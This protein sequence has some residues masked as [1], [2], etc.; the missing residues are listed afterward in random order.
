MEQRAETL[1]YGSEVVVH[2]LRKAA[3]TESRVLP[4]PTSDL[5]EDPISYH[6]RP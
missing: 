3:L 4:E 6:F 5:G 1:D 2:P